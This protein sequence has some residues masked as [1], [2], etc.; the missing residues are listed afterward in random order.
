MDIR[1]IESRDLDYIRQR[2]PQCHQPVY[3]ISTYAICWKES[4]Q[5]VNFH[6]IYD[7]FTKLA[8]KQICDVCLRDTMQALVNQ[9]IWAKSAVT[10]QRWWRQIYRRPESS[11]AQTYVVLMYLLYGGKIDVSIPARHL[12]YPIKHVLTDIGHSRPDILR[13]AEGERTQLGHLLDLLP[14][15]SCTVTISNLRDLAA[16]TPEMTL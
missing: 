11:Y 1:C 4:G 6:S 2:C 7:K 13:K 8:D 10:I 12:R 14:P 16:I 5:M 3:S 15:G 9:P